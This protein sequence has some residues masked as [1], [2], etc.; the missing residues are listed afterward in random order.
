MLQ[1][2]RP[3]GT[4]RTRVTPAPGVGLA[5][6]ACNRQPRRSRPAAYLSMPLGRQGGRAGVW[7][8]CLRSPGGGAPLT[9][10]RRRP[11][12]GRAR[13]PGGTPQLT[14]G[15]GGPQHMSAARPTRC[16]RR[17]PQHPHTCYE[18]GWTLAYMPAYMAVSRPG[19]RSVHARYTLHTRPLHA[20]PHGRATRSC[21]PECTAAATRRRGCRM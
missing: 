5:G 11:P 20:R 7:A 1:A 13:T 9:G 16:P 2:G 15:A 19:T 14:V 3:A 8:C 10:T 17:P 18:L 12:Q 21:H 6:A 4:R